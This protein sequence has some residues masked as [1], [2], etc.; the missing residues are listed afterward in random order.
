MSGLF[1]VIMR[2]SSSR[3][4][5]N[6]VEIDQ[7]II[8]NI[9][10]KANSAP[11]RVIRFCLQVGASPAAST[12][13]ENPYHRSLCGRFLVILKPWKNLQSSSRMGL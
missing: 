7:V 1:L 12:K 6:L 4:F 8:K 3:V 13:F 10:V 2:A 11:S 5:I 9:E